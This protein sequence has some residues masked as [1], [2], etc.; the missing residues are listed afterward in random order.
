[1]QHIIGMPPHII[2]MGMP[3]P[4]MPI[5]LSQASFII[6]VDMPAIGVMVQTIMSPFISHDMVHMGTIIGIMP[7]I[8]EFIIGI[9]PIIGFI[10]PIIGIM[11]PI[12]APIIW[13]IIGIMFIIGIIPWVIMPS[14]ISGIILVA[15]FVVIVL[16]P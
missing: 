5:I 1:M 11:L 10:M 13:F 3:L 7:P 2:I 8:M 14:V 16:F 12:M 15:V 9:M 6:C 4:I